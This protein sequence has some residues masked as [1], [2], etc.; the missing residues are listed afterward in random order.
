M[1]TKGGDVSTAKRTG[2]WGGIA[3]A[4]LLLAGP[5]AAAEG[6]DDLAVVRRAVASAE[7]TQ[8]VEAPQGA[9]ESRT[10]RR[11]EA[12][13]GPAWLKLSIVGD[14]DDGASLSLNL[15]LALVR[16][17]DD[18]ACDDGDRDEPGLSDLLAGLVSGQP[19][20]S[21]DADEAEVRVWVE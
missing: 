6:D 15:P 9:G 13:T 20:V 17:I 2:K 21:I 16:V 14:G 3:C 1:R 11:A 8:R 18:L 12:R 19:L 10:P 7:R 4:C 5:A